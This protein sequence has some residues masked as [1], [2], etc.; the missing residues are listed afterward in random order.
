M[1]GRAR[2]PSK[3]AAPGWEHFEH[4]ADIGVRGFGTTVEEAFEQAAVAVTAAVT[5]PASVRPT[6]TVAIECRADDRELL[7]VE[8]LNAVIC[9]G[10]VHGML[11]GA[12]RVRLDGPLLHGTLS[13]E[14]VDR[15]RHQ[16][17]VEPKGATCTA[18]RVM[19]R[20]DGVWL[21]QCVIDV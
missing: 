5:D 20:P 17:A 14:A 19:Q 7:L 15:E 6:R 12:F 10:S 8:W 16:P 4:S 18:L 13:G 21:A 1:H 3:P 9:E 2:K 11:F